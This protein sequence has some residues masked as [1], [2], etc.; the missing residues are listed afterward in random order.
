MLQTVSDTQPSV[1]D[2]LHD[3]PDWVYVLREF[4]DL[5]HRSSAGGS[6]KIR[7]HQRV[8]R[9]NISKIIDSSPTL[10][11]RSPVTKPVCKHL[12]RA[13]DK[14]R[15]QPTAPTIRAI[16]SIVDQLAWHYGYEKLPKHLANKFAYAEIAG[17][18]GPIVYE[19]L[20]LGLVLFAPKCVYPTHSHDSI[21]ESYFCLSG[22][23]S[24]NDDGVFAP[25]SLI[26]N[27]PGRNHRITV[28]DR[29]PCLLAYTWV[30]APDKLANQK[31]VLSKKR[32]SK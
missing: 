29:E 23:M 5:Y 24:E 3:D 4:Y 32:S 7:S 1:A 8:V 22:A 28:A 14:G 6:P 13:L 15:L 11:E 9:E 16:E 25:G 26:L 20:I 2:R 19:K 31:M 17:P 30:G 10:A 27:P 21:T 18:N 12:K